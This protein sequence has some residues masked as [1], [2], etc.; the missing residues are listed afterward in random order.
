VVNDSMGTVFSR[1]NRTDIHMNTET[2]TAQDLHRFK[3][4]R[5]AALGKGSGHSVSLLTMKPFLIDDC[6][7]REKV[8][9]IECH[10][11]YQK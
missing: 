5:V 1:H 11:L 2:V 4:A 7:Q 8:F 6:W 9:S 10:W 3:P